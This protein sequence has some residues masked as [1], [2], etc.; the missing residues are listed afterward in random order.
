M[1]PT[2]PQVVLVTGCSTGIGR[3]TAIRLADDGMIVY[4]T[5]RR[6]ADIAELEALGCRT[7]VLDV[8]SESSMTAAV[9][10]VISEQG[11]V[12]SLVNNAGYSLSG[13][14]ED[15]PL[16]KIRQQF[17]TNVFGLIYMCQLVLPAMR[18]QGWGRIV[19]IGSMG[20]RLTFPGGGAYHA[21]KYAVEAISD[22]LRFE[23]KDFGVDVVLVEPGLIRTDFAKAVAA[24]MTPEGRTGGVYDEFNEQVLEMTERTYENPLLGRLGGDPE[25]VAD[26]IAKALTAKRPRARYAVTPSATLMITQRKFTPDRVWD[27]MLTLQLDR[28]KP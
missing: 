16:D 1:T 10:H 27:K 22:A 4:A 17:D 18:K 25:V 28:P 20:G 7:L 8:N 2:Q 13:A 21:T 26:V 19:N 3:A 5:A 23:V 9:E 6:S 11:R 15:L 12:D 14:I 24:H